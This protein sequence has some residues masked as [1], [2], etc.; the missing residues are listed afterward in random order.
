M[1]MA[2]TFIFRGRGEKNPWAFPGNKER[3]PGREG[4]M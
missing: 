2:W 4:E 1:G 3:E